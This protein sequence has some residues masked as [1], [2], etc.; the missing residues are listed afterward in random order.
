[1]KHTFYN[2]LFGCL[3]ALSLAGLRAEVTLA[4]DT[5]ILGAW[6][7]EA[8]AIKLDGKKAEEQGTWEFKK[9]GALDVTSYYKFANQERTINQRYHIENGQT[10]V[11]DKAGKYVIVEKDRDRMVLHGPHGFYFFRKK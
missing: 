11:T 8:H 2:Y 3:L 5:E 1:M 9:N 6:A 7:L 4:D 10:I